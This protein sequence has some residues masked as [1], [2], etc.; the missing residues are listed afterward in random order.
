ML[1]SVMVYYRDKGKQTDEKSE[2]NIEKIM[3]LTK[4]RNFSKICI[5]EISILSLWREIQK[6]Y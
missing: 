6:F 1:L 4:K 3:Q 2:K 5:F